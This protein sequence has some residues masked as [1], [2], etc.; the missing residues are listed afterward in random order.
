MI[1]YYLDGNKLEVDESNKPKIPI[2]PTPVG[3]FR[4]IEIELE[5]TGEW[6]VEFIPYSNDIDLEITEH[7]TSLNPTEK[8]RLVLTFKPNEE[9]WEPLNTLW[10][11]KILI[12]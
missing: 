7:P 5:N 11:F 4:R 9:R 10:G 6:P 3:S 8:G 1:V 2:E 12:G